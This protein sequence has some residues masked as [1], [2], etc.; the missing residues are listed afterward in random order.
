MLILYLCILNYTFILCIS[1][2][3]ILKTLEYKFSLSIFVLSDFLLCIILLVFVMEHV[4]TEVQHCAFIHLS[5]LA[6]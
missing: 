2:N 1:I 5:G 3:L 4:G 6:I